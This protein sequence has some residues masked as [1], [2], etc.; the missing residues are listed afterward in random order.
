MNYSRN[1]KKVSI[2]KR[3]L[4][5]WVVVAI[6]FSLIG[7]GIGTIS[8]K[9]GNSSPHIKPAT[10][11]EILIFGKPD[12]KIFEGEVPGEWAGDL[13]FVPLDVPMDEDLQEFVF[14]LSEAYEMDFT[15]VMAL[16]QQE[17]GFQSDIV[18]ST[19]DYGLM[20]INEV[21][22]PYL[23][24]QLEITDFLNPYDNIRAGMFM[25]RKLFEKYETPAKVLMAYNMGEGGAFYLWRQGIF[26]INYS[27]LVLQI[28]QEMNV[29]LERSSNND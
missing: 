7:F 5:S 26:E 16:I 11:K 20:Q 24:E 18:S 23:K 12:G 3:V 27:K 14:Y 6:L 22:H 25:L 13:K 2:G 15:F 10:S 17:S 1:I 4:I 9:S 28:Q 8:A 19:N 29:E 21:N